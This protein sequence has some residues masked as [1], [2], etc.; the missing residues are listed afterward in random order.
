[1]LLYGSI[2]LYFD[3]KLKKIPNKFTLLFFI[4]GILRCY[5]TGEFSLQFLYHFLFS[6]FLF[7]SIY[8]V[9]A[10]G[11]GDAKFYI[12]LYLFIGL[13]GVA[14]ISLVMLILS[15]PMGLLFGTENGKGIKDKRAYFTYLVWQIMNEPRCMNH[16]IRFPL[17]LAIYPAIWCWLIFIQME[18]GTWSTFTIFR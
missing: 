18:V 1:M 15:I 5:V 6:I 17:M 10:I 11:A 14:F 4:I 13:K 12:V 16:Q 3:L 7:V 8:L 2:A 9:G